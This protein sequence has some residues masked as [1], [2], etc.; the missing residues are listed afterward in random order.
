M[1]TKSLA[2]LGFAIIGTFS[3]AVARGED[4]FLTLGGGTRHRENQASLE[5]MCCSSSDCFGL[6]SS[7]G[8]HRVYFADGFDGGLDLQVLQRTVSSRI[9]P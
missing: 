1:I 5:P 9:L 4:Y 6:N 7:M 2:A 3:C 8:T